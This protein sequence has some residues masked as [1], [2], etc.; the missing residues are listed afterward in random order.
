MT[1][2]YYRT[3]YVI[4]KTLLTGTRNTL[5]WDTIMLVLVFN[6]PSENSQPRREGQNDA[7]VPR[8]AAPQS[9]K[10]V[11]ISVRIGNYNAAVSK[12]DRHR[13]NGVR[14]QSMIS[15]EVSA[16]PACDQPAHTD[17]GASSS[18]DTPL[19]GAPKISI[20]LP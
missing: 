15:S 10:Q 18:T 16:T 3:L 14:G 5:E 19:A 4:V 13:G 11:R 2:N 8:S 20:Q 7:E 6:S 9:P 12:G 1:F 17:P